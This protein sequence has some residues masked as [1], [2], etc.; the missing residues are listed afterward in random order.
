MTNREKVINFLVKINH[1]G[2]DY[3][4][5]EYASPDLVKDRAKEAGV[6]KDL[7]R[8]LRIAII[9]YLE[10]KESL[11]DTLETIK[12]SFDIRDEEVEV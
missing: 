11:E 10:A 6:S 8:E 5:S 3:Y 9:D 12:D 1:E 2:F 4:F 7:V